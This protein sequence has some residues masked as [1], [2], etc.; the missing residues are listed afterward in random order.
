MNRETKNLGY[1][2][3]FA[4][5]IMF[6][7]M[8]GIVISNKN[9][10]YESASILLGIF[11]IIQFLL[12]YLMKKEL[13]LDI[14]SKWFFGIGNVSLLAIFPI[15][16][17]SDLLSGFFETEGAIYIYLAI[18]SAFVGFI[19]IVTSIVY[20]K[21]EFL[22]VS[23]AS[24]FILMSFLFK[25]YNVNI[26]YVMITL[27]ALVLLLNIFA[28]KNSIYSVSKLFTFI[29]PCIMLLI[30]QNINVVESLI[31]TI[32]S[33]INVLLVM[34]RNKDLETSL[35]SLLIIFDVLTLF[36]INLLNNA[37]YNLS[38][39]IIVSLNLLVM[40][41]IDYF[42]FV[43]KKYL[44]DSYKIINYGYLICL[45]AYM[46][47]RSTYV[48]LI[49][50]GLILISMIANKLLFKND[51]ISSYSLPV[52]I[53]FITIC[54]LS[55]IS[56]NYIYISYNLALFIINIVL[57]LLYKFNK[58]YELKIVY[59]ILIVGILTNLVLIKT[60]TLLGFIINFLVILIDYVF[61][62]LFDNKKN[63]FIDYM[64]YALLVILPIIQVKYLSINHIKYLLLGFVYMI[65]LYKNHDDK[66]K[67]AFTIITLLVTLSMY[68]DGVISTVWLS[69]IMITTLIIV[70]I[71]VFSYLIMPDSPDNSTF[72]IVFIDLL[73]LN[74]L[75]Y[76]KVIFINLY[77]FIAAL[78]MI[79][80]SI[81][82]K[83]DKLS[84]VSGLIYSFV[85]LASM[86]SLLSSYPAFIYLFVIG[87]VLMII[88]IYL[89]KNSKEKVQYKVNFCPNCGEKVKNEDKFCSN[90]GEKIDEK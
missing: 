19:S 80:Y 55:F 8:L 18:I 26:F 50:A 17:K 70:G 51:K 25:Y 52:G 40:L 29:L 16:Y 44:I 2:L 76:R 78:V 63:S 10:S 88:V 43:N 36:D 56:K 42:K 84:L 74:L 85:S 61:V 37:E 67:S 4:G 45:T 1:V 48:Y 9:I 3:N 73:L 53:M 82:N 15:L 35:L 32:L 86:I 59:S 65:L 62:T 34:S 14:S 89:I 60:D 28:Y 7:A 21:M 68:I 57:L 49:S 22:K 58:N 33:L 30:S 87:F 64:L 83:D 13:N 79:L 90:C 71:N 31:F 11:A 38:L 47:N 69:K 75:D 27:S 6:I 5:A 46:I 72:N 77:I 39:P 66:I 20:N 24:F 54:L 81:K 12:S 23:Y 41:I